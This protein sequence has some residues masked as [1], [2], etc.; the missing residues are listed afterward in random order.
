MYKKEEIEGKI[1]EIIKNSDNGLYISKI[2]RK[3]GVSHQTAS[4]FIHILEAEKKI[5]VEKVGDM[6]MVRMR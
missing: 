2:A 5:R 1:L 4:K 6:K 3:I